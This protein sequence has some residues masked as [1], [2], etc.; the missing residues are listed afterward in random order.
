MCTLIHKAHN[1]SLLCLSSLNPLPTQW[2]LALTIK[3]NEDEP[4]L[5]RLVKLHVDGDLNF[6]VERFSKR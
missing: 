2:A 4:S 1:E 3:Q 5:A 6:H